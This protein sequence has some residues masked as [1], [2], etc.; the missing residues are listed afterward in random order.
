MISFEGEKNNIKNKKPIVLCVTIFML[1]LCNFLSIYKAF[2]N[3]ETH[4]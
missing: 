1:C 2:H 3:R 4:Q